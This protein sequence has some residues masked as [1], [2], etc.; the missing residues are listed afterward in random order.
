[1][2]PLPASGSSVH[3]LFVHVFGCRRTGWCDAS[4]PPLVVLTRWV[5]ARLLAVT[6][7]LALVLQARARGRGFCRLLG[8]LTQE[9]SSRSSP[10][11]L[12]EGN[13][14]RSSTFDSL[15]LDQDDS[16]KAVLRLIREF[17]SL[18]EPESVIPNWCKTSLAPV[19]GLQSQSSPALHLPLSPLL[20]SLLEDTKLG[21]GQVCGRPDRTWF[22]SRSR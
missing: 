7:L 11:P 18:E 22:P 1:M 3:L 16:F 5:V 2:E 13:D 6:A 21:F 14:D 8:R 20:R 15:D 19:Y 4:S 9:Y 10:T 12:G 17:H